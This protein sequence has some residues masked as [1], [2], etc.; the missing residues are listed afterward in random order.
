METTNEREG[1]E[2]KTE[3]NDQTQEKRYWQ[4]LKLEKGRSDKK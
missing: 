4:E 1:K 3:V 2:K